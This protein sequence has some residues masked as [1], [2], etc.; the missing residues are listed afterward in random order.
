[1][2]VADEIRAA[3]QPHP[4]AA[5]TLSGSLAL[6]FGTVRPPVRPAGAPV[7]THRMRITPARLPDLPP[8]T[9]KHPAVLR[10]HEPRALILRLMI[11]LGEAMR[12]ADIAEAAGI[13]EEMV[14][15]RMTELK[16]LGVV[17]VERISRAAFWEAIEADEEDG[18]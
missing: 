5:P 12:R 9:N 15:E 18:E 6:L 7:R 11:E 10:T 2:S 1:M 17:R 14:G 3:R 4:A 16:K 8:A 13:S